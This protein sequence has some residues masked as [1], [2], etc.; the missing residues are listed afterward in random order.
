[1]DFYTN[2]VQWGNFLLVRGVDKNQ[3]VNFRLKYK[4]T[5]FV[6]VMK[7]TDWKTLDGKSVTPYQFD[8]IKDAKDFLLKYESQAHLVHGLNRFAYTYIS[9][10]FP[11][12][13][14][15][16]I[17][18]I[19]IMTIDIEVQCENGF[20]NPESAIEPLL[21]I[22]VK[23]QQS[24]KIIV[25]GIQPYKNTRE[26]VTYIRCPN[27]HDLIMEFMSFWTKNYPDVITGWNTDFFDIPYLA[28]R[29]KQVCGEDKMRELS[30]WK[31]VSS[32]Q[33][34]SMGRNHLMYDIMGV[35]QYDYLQLYQKFTYTRQ[36][37]YKLDYI[38]SVELGEKKDENP[39][40][41][42]REWYENDFQSFIDYNI[43]DVEI[44][45]KL[46]DKM[47]LIDLALTMAYEGK[48]NY[49]DVFGQ[50]KYWDILIYNFL[51]K[52]K[53]VIPQKNHIVK[54]NNMRV[55]M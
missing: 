53:I 7:Q 42:F 45:D 22:T 18:K 27:E 37:S 55:H 33:I 40:E 5:L 51:R 28:N 19:L 23:N 16:N 34:Y 10:T 1:M 32:K 6:P 47:G 3:R 54:T 44:V 14:N 39:Y 49:S 31:N 9:D 20:P 35:S 52:R 13:V 41:T 4:P 29:I 26:D 21:S 43:Q 17:D 30:P 15:W 11:Q 12:K 38:A 36:E 2:V 50:V 24:K 25:W 48:V 46:E 8:C